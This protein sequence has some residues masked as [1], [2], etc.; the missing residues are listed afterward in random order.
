MLSKRRTAAWL[1][2]LISTVSGLACMSM[3]RIDTSGGGPSARE[4]C[5]DVRSVDS[6]SPLIE[7]FVHVRRL[8]DEQYLL[9]L[10]GV[11]TSLP[12]ATGI[13]V[14]NDFGHVCSDT[15][16]LIRYMDF[17][18]PAVCRIIRVEGAAS[19]E[20]A[21]KLAEE[22]TTPKG[23]EVGPLSARRTL[24]LRQAPIA[25]AGNKLRRMVAGTTRRVVQA[26][27]ATGLSNSS[28]RLDLGVAPE[29]TDQGGAKVAWISVVGHLNPME[30]GSR[31]SGRN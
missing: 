7:R 8:G 24:G 14:S 18:R 6:F 19:K 21:E 20:A 23:F 2:G 28:W 25:V 12:F 11:Y 22:R 5:F 30:P 4:A 16:A 27:R 1:L 31:W 29:R 10:D 26:T 13:T 15:G 3:Q 9:T 17:G